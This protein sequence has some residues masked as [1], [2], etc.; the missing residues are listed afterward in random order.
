MQHSAFVVHFPAT[1]VQAPGVEGAPP[2][3]PP[4]VGGASQL[5]FVQLPEQQSAP[6]VQAPAAGAHFVAHTFVPGSQKPEQQS[7]SFA[8]VAFVALHA[9]GGRMQRGGSWVLSQRSLSGVAR[10]HPR[11]G[12]D[13]QVSPVGRHSEL[14]SSISHFPSAPQM[15]EQQSAFA[16]QSSPYTAQS[17]F[18]HTP[19]KHP[20]EQQSCA[21]EQATPSALHAS[22]HWM[23]PACPVTGWHRPLQQ[24]ALDVHAACGTRHAPPAAPV[25]GPAGGATHLPPLH[26]PA[27]HSKPF[28]HVAPGA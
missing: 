6:D 26:V 7:A 20:S 28:A 11:C 3:L 21:R 15:P 4:V 9:V 25:P 22:V 24:D 8:H 16:A 2:L 23:T 19:P 14:A 12:P 17:L 27:Q 13:V 1:G 18:A 5:P 10:Q